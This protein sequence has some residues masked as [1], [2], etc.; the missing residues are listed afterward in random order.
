MSRTLRLPTW[1][2]TPVQPRA[3]T[4]RSTDRDVEEAVAVR[5]INR[6]RRRRRVHVGPHQDVAAR[7]ARDR[8][9]LGDLRTQEPVLRR[10]V[11]LN[12]DIRREEPRRRGAQRD[13]GHR[14]EAEAPLRTDA[15]RAQLRGRQA[16]RG[17]RPLLGRAVPARARHRSRRPPV[18]RRAAG[19]RRRDDE[20]RRARHHAGRRPRHRRRRGRDHDPAHELDRRAP[21]A[22]PHPRLDADVRPRGRDVQRRGR[23]SHGSC[24]RKVPARQR[25]GR[26]SPRE[27]L[28]AAR[29]CRRHRGRRD[30][31]VDQVLQTRPSEDAPRDPGRTPAALGVSRRC[32]PLR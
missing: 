32:S 9:H 3:D 28:R 2:G 13:V 31:G 24:Q 16:R 11:Q 19:R 12:S 15:H 17:E 27:L 6:H 1:R 8:E 26:Q 5:S 21:R 23:R 10:P 29:P 14:R 4:M 7:S 22:R 20:R 18:R 25:Q 30:V